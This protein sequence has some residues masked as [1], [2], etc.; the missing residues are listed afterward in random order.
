[1]RQDGPALGAAD[2]RLVAQRAHQADSAHRR[3]RESAPAPSA[4]TRV[5]WSPAS[6]AVDLAEHVSSA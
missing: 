4:R 6:S 2:I 5:R 1:V 3:F